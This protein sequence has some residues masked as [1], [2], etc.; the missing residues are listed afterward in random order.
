[1][2][3]ETG[4]KAAQAAQ[5]D[6]AD[7]VGTVGS[8]Q[9]QQLQLKMQWK[10]SCDFGMA[11]WESILPTPVSF[12]SLLS[13]CV[14]VCEWLGI[15]TVL[16]LFD[17][18]A[19]NLPT[20]KTKKKKKAG[21]KKIVSIVAGLVFSPFVFCFWPVRFARAFYAASSGPPL[22]L[23][24]RRPQQPLTQHRHRHRHLSPAR[25][26]GTVSA[27]N[28]KVIISVVVVVVLFFLFFRFV[29]APLSFGFTRV[30]WGVRLNNIYLIYFYFY[31]INLIFFNWTS[32]SSS[33]STSLAL[34]ASQSDYWLFRFWIVFFFLGFRFFGFS[35]FV[36]SLCTLFKS[37]VVKPL[38]RPKHVCFND[39]LLVLAPHSCP[40]GPR[41]DP[42]QEENWVQSIVQLG[43]LQGLGWLVNW[44]ALWP[45]CLCLLTGPISS[46]PGQT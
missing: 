10:W 11:G 5:A 37:Y 25:Q 45:I 4:C 30:G 16:W 42:L 17:A 15:V 12:V 24:Q 13:D 44:L 35:T 7:R 31:F 43:P 28:W 2:L 3:G 32:S 36:R 34:F 39:F 41:F 8:G 29:L 6:K 1:M 33:S 23:R 14:C 26:G 22:R 40:R 27:S 20:K 18:N 9:Q 38:F 21:R 46:C 19:Q